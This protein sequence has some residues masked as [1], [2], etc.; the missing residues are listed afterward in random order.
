MTA[1]PPIISPEASP[2]PVLGAILEYVRVRI[3]ITEGQRAALIAVLDRSPEEDVRVAAF[4]LSID[5]ADPIGWLEARLAEWPRGAFPRASLYAVQRK[6]SQA[7][8][9]QVEPDLSATEAT[10]PLGQAQPD[11]GTPS[12]EEAGS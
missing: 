6:L 1:P 9:G 5:H 8:Q 11:L 10:E 12:S 7:I 4:T 2:G 3:H